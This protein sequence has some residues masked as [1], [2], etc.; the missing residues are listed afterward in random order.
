MRRRQ[1]APGHL[2]HRRRQGVKLVVAAGNESPDAST[3]DPAA[4]PEVIAVRLADLD[5][6]PGDLGT[7]C[8]AE[9]TADVGET[10]C[11]TVLVSAE[12][13]RTALLACPRGKADRGR[14]AC[15]VR[16]VKAHQRIAMAIAGVLAIGVGGGTVAALVSGSGEAAQ[17]RTGRA[18]TA[19]EA[20]R[21]ALARFQMY[22]GT[23]THFRSQVV[24]AGSAV[25]LSGDVDFRRR[26][27]LAQASVQGKDSFTLQWNAAN[28][29]AWP[30][31]SGVLEPP[32][33]LPSTDP[34]MRA[35]DPATIG[36]DSILAL[37]L[38]LGQDRPDE[39]Q[40]L[41]QNGTAWLRRERVN[42]IDCDVVAGPAAE[43][44]KAGNVVY[45]VGP[46]SELPRV[47]AYLG[48]G[49]TATRVDLDPRAFTP[50][51]AA[52][53]FAAG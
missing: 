50:F 5:G 22:R 45:W 33:R 38:A 21:L 6:K 13:S 28:L 27:G 14:V 24:S 15:R 30:G 7:T 2:L 26:L 51:D 23:G 41:R 53:G 35:L 44:A 4:Y 9:T 8:Y 10:R 1:R 25:D 43:G 49:A 31:G 32:A 3:S 47:E 29:A 40:Q 52:K 48:G 18:L 20:D 11:P 19:A 42:G 34:E 37:M 17:S 12:V 36:V 46:N 16:P 39:A